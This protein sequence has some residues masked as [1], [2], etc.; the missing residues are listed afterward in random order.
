MGHPFSQAFLSNEKDIIDSVKNSNL[1]K[2]ITYG[3][4]KNLSSTE[5]SSDDICLSLLKQFLNESPGR[6]SNDQDDTEYD[7][8]FQAGDYITLF[9]KMNCFINLSKRTTKQITNT[10]TTPESWNTLMIMVYK[11]IQVR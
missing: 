7:F 2:Q 4:S 1:H 9:I 3:L 5:F 6:F 8:P 10:T 11:Y